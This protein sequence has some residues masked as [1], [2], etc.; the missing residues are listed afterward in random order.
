MKKMLFLA[1]ALVLM[2]SYGYAQSENSGD[3]SSGTESSIQGSTVSDLAQNTT[4]T[5]KEKGS[6][7]SSAARAKALTVANANARFLRGDAKPTNAS[8]NTNANATANANVNSVLSL[9]SSATLN[10]KPSILPP[11]TPPTTGQPLS[12][13]VGAPMGV[14]VGVQAVTHVAAGLSHH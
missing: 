9:S 2:G 7:I 4:V 11:V 5:G 1:S 3:H 10:G 13:P 14:P 8:A 6:L 12:T